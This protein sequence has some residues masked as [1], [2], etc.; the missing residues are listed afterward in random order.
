MDLKKVYKA[1]TKEMA[2]QALVELE[3]KWGKK[4]PIVLKSWTD[5]W[6]KLSAYFSY[7]QPIRRLIYTTNIIE[8]YHRQLRKVTKNK[9]AFPSD[10]ALLKLVYLATKNISKK[11]THP[12]PNWGL[13]AQQLSI[14]FGN[15]MQLDLTLKK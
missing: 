4:Y 13:V 12:L 5:N 8:G 7:T 11:W 15:R 1:S 3:G 2:E 6:D 14:K 9:G 10:M